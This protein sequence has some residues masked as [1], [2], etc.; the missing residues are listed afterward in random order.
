LTLVD[1]DELLLPYLAEHPPLHIVVAAFVG[2][3]PRR[4][5]NLPNSTHDLREAM[6]ALGSRRDV[7]EGFRDPVIL[8]FDRLKTEAA[9]KRSA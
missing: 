9:R 2:V 4:K 7:H 5:G 8:D 3:K 6:Q 1:L